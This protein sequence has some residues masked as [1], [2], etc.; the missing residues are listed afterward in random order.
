[1]NIPLRKFFHSHQWFRISKRAPFT[2]NPNSRDSTVDHPKKDEHVDYAVIFLPPRK[3]PAFNTASFGQ[4]PSPPQL[5]PGGQHIDTSL[6]QILQS[7]F[8]EFVAEFVVAFNP[9][10]D[11]EFSV[12]KMPLVVLLRPLRRGKPVGK[13]SSLAMTTIVP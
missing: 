7:G 12:G 3:Y 10:S 5:T 13:H 8:V 11:D 6:S 9:V 1:M 2:I 4:N